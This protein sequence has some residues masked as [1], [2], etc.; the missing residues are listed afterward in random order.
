M[1]GLW[2]GRYVFCLPLR[3]INMVAR[4]SY[5]AAERSPGRGLKGE[6]RI[7]RK[8]ETDKKKRQF[9]HRSSKEILMG[10]GKTSAIKKKI[11]SVIELWRLWLMDYVITPRSLK[12]RSI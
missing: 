1:E 2:R 3:S 7:V 4:G 6:E 10:E 9:S 11:A 5:Q 12:I 8:R